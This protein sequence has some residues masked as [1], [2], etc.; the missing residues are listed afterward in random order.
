MANLTEIKALLASLDAPI[1]PPKAAY[2]APT[3]EHVA[4]HEK[5]VSAIRKHAREQLQHRHDEVAAGR[6][7]PLDAFLAAGPPKS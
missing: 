1:E 3:A 2:G 6:P 5:R 4:E 7:D